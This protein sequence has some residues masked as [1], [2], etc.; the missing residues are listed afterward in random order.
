MIPEIGHFS[1]ILCFAL[2]FFG[3]VLS[4][5]KPS[6]QSLQRIS[7]SMLLTASIAFALLMYSFIVSD[8]SVSLIA[9]N[10]HVLKPMLYKVSG[11]WG[12]HE[13]SML[14]WILI[15]TGILSVYAYKSS[16]H[17][18]NQRKEFFYFFCI[19]ALFLTYT[20][21]LSN[22]FE[23]LSPAP[24]NGQDLN[25]VLQDP[26]LAIHP[27]LLFI[28]YALTVVPFIMLLAQLDKPPL[29]KDF[30][31]R[32]LPWLHGSWLFLAGGL[33]LGSW[34]A[35]Y[36]LGWGGWWFWD[37]VEN[38]ALLPW[39]AVTVLIHNIL[40]LKAS[41][42][43]AFGSSLLIIF[44]FCIT[45]LG[46][47]IVRSG[48]ISS[49]HSFAL[50]PTR[51]IWLLALF[52]FVTGYALIKLTSKTEQL[53]ST[54]TAQINLLSR[55]RFLDVHFWIG[56]LMIIFVLLGTLIPFWGEMIFGSNIA[57]GYNYYKITFIPLGLAT[58]ILMGFA[59]FFTWRQSNLKAIKNQLLLPVIFSTFLA[60][61][62]IL[63][64]DFA[65]LSNVDSFLLIAFVL[66][67]VY[68]IVLSIQ[69]LKL[70]KKLSS[71]AIAHMGLAIAVL[72]MLG[73][74]FLS[75]ET[76]VDMHINETLDLAGYN[77]TLKDVQP[78]IIDNYNADRAIIDV[79]K[80]ET[81]ITHMQPE[82]RWYPIA[83]KQTREVDLHYRTTSFSDF[84]AV[85][86]A[87]G[88]KS[89][90]SWVINIR[91]NPYISL[92]WIGWTIMMLGGVVAIIK[93]VK[94]HRKHFDT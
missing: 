28:G 81:L 6:L 33:A 20:V 77:F 2:S 19:I 91:Y 59:P 17:S 48:I 72:G 53:A 85:I 44:A 79:K 71:T 92:L 55:E 54:K 22:P 11:T 37:P 39:L 32:V 49:V 29:N 13:G 62:W 82:L 84:Y 5:T 50:D 90:D 7:L 89:E 21:L 70:K 65:D 46:T 25:P 27:P 10:S 52:G 35:Y 51:G 68:A 61:L 36:E 87:R 73:S 31:M 38:V 58:V 66:S 26:A 63:R 8:F 34:W 4:W 30:A 18:D 74:G 93:K 23:R 56:I 76:R 14:L 43:G 12:N 40:Q 60:L 1:L 78:L 80:N 16:A 88:Q 3:M 24:L 41:N 69:R 42:K 75:K 86:E 64:H 94:K 9:D 57:V 15:F 83:G 67:S 45:L 47:F